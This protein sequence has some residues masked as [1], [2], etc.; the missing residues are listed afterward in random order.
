MR[1]TKRFKENALLIAFGVILFFAV[2][3][4]TLALDILGYIKSILY[5]VILGAIMAFIFNVPMSAI[6]KHLFK[7][8]KNPKRQKLVASIKRPCS[9]VLTPS[10]VSHRVSARYPRCQRIS[11]LS[12]NISAM[13]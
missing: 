8:P 4:Y 13:R 7:T 12:L 2:T 9:I 3:N 10:G 1:F 6:E 11:P 5:P